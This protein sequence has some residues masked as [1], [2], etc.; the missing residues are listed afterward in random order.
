MDSTDLNKSATG[1]ETFG[2][3]S[4]AFANCPTTGDGLLLAKEPVTY[5]L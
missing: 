4:W 1:D 2:E 3:S 5:R